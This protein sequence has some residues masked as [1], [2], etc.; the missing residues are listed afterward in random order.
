MPPSPSGT[1]AWRAVAEGPSPG[2]QR[3]HAGT[4][5]TRGH[6]AER[7]VS[8]LPPPTRPV[9][10]TPPYR[11]ASTRDE[12]HGWC[13]FRRRRPDRS[14][15]PTVEKVGGA[16]DSSPHDRCSSLAV[17]CAFHG[18]SRDLVTQ[19]TVS[20]P[21]PCCCV[22][23]SW[24]TRACDSVRPR[25]PTSRPPGRSHRRRLGDDGA[26]AGRPTCCSSTPPDPTTRAE[27]GSPS[28]S[29][30]FSSPDDRHT[31]TA[32]RRRRLAR[33]PPRRHQPRADRRRR[34]RQLGAHAPGHA[35]RGRA[36]GAGR[37]GR[38]RDLALQLTPHQRTPEPLRRARNL[39]RRSRAVAAHASAWTVSLNGQ[40]IPCMRCVSRQSPRTWQQPLHPERVA[41]SSPVVATFPPEATTSGADRAP[42]RGEV[43]A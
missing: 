25:R 28:T 12:H 2:S 43:Q 9:A 1:A 22:M 5:P 41:R 31:S 20:G 34:C 42:H 23:P 40:S 8:D 37:P 33:G 35:T 21:S 19:G 32:H 15:T 17:G 26:W 27:P 11:P 10:A 18:D 36:P 13:A 29:V 7:G 39:A 30:P 14:T 6:E 16:L 4:D 24:C 38:R 3:E